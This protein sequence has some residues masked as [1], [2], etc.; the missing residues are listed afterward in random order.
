MKLIRYI[1]RNFKLLDIDSNL[2]RTAFRHD[3]IEYYYAYIGLHRVLGEKDTRLFEYWENA[4]PVTYSAWKAGEPSRGDCTKMGFYKATDNNTWES[5][6][7]N[8]Q[9]AFYFVC[10]YNIGSRSIDIQDRVFPRDYAGNHSLTSTGFTCQRWDSQQPHQHY[11]N[12]DDFFPDTSVSDASNYCRELGRGYLW[13]FTT[14]P[15][16]ET[17]VCYPN[18]IHVLVKYDE[19]F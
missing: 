17:D 11:L 19:S 15:K 5:V 16:V 3:K 1:L 13:C 18:G 7:C 9:A 14:N 8:E 2:F 10:E 6:D 12:K 4:T